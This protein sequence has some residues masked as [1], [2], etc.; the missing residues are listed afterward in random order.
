MTLDKLDTISSSDYVLL[1]DGVA[2]IICFSCSRPSV[3]SRRIFFQRPNFLQT[4]SVH[5]ILTLS[6]ESSWP[7]ARPATTNHFNISLTPSSEK[8]VCSP[9]IPPDCSITKV[10][11][12][13]TVRGFSITYAPNIPGSSIALGSSK[14]TWAVAPLLF[15]AQNVFTFTRNL[16]CVSNC[17]L[18]LSPFFVIH[19]H[20]CFGK[21]IDAGVE[22]T[23]WS[24]I[25]EIY[26]FSKSASPLMAKNLLAECTALIVSNFP[27]THPTMIGSIMIRTAPCS[28][29]TCAFDSRRPSSS[30]L[31]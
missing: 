23:P 29:K 25:N 26:F 12:S 11:K 17:T 22:N 10:N 8:R 18:I 16:K 30:S 19:S 4:D 3:R 7:S 21:R 9:A 31:F 15:G 27:T 13:C 5:S 6:R 14:S 28:I 24:P 20:Q 2:L 1:C